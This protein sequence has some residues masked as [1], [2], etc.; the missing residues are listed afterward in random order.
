MPRESCY[1]EALDM[2]LQYGTTEVGM[3]EMGWGIVLFLWQSLEGIPFLSPWGWWVFYPH[4]S[5]VQPQLA[6]YSHN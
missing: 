6:K 4:I 5:K 2:L 1:R 3:G